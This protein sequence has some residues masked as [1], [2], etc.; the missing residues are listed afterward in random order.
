M[1]L[2]CY[3]VLLQMRVLVVV[4]FQGLLPAQGCHDD[5]G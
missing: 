1:G 2:Y 5:L 4:I 3:T